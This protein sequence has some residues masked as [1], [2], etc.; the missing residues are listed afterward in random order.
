MP[1]WLIT[2]LTFICLIVISFFVYNSFVQASDIDKDISRYALFSLDKSKRVKA[3]EKRIAEHVATGDARVEGEHSK[4]WDALNKTEKTAFG[5]LNDT[6]GKRHLAYTSKLELAQNKLMQELDAYEKSKATLEQK[7]RGVDTAFAKTGTDVDKSGVS[8]TNKIGEFS[9]KV[10]KDF[11]RLDTAFKFITADFGKVI[12]QIKSDV[13]TLKASSSGTQN[14]IELSKK[15]LKSTLLG[16]IS[17]LTNQ[18]LNYEKTQNTLIA[19]LDDK[20][21]TVAEKARLIEHYMMMLSSMD[22]TIATLKTNI[23]KIESDM[24][25]LTRDTI[26]QLDISNNG[27]IAQ[28]N[29]V[30][31]ALNAQSSAISEYA[32]QLKAD[33]ATL[34][35]ALAT[36]QKQFT[37]SAPTAQLSTSL[38][39]QLTDVQ[40]QLSSYKTQMLAT[41]AGQKGTLIADQERV[42]KLLKDLAENMPADLPAELTKIQ[43][44][45]TTFVQKRDA[46]F[47]QLNATVNSQ[48]AQLNDMLPKAKALQD[49]ISSK[50]PSVTNIDPQI[51]DLKKRIVAMTVKLAEYVP[52]TRYSTELEGVRQTLGSLTTTLDGVKKSNTESWNKLGSLTYISP[53]AMKKEMA[54]I[55]GVSPTSSLVG[56]A[57]YTTDTTDLKN[58]LGSVIDLSKGGQV[59]G[60]LVVQG[61][62]KAQTGNVC[63]DDVCWTKA[64]LQKVKAAG[65]ILYTFTSHTFTTAGVS[66]RTGPTLAQ[67]K[68]AYSSASW[69][70]NTNFFN[71]TTQGIQLWTVPS[72]K[73]YTITVAG[74]SAANSGSFQGGKGS[75]V[76]STF[77]LTQGHKLLI[78]VGQQSSINKQNNASGGG[79]GT[80]VV[81]ETTN[82]LMLAAGGGGGANSGS[83]ASGLD[84]PNSQNGN[85]G[86]PG[87]NG[88]GGGFSGLPGST[89]VGGGG[90]GYVSRGNQGY[91]GGKGGFSLSSGGNGG[92]ATVYVTS[93]SEVESG[94][95]GFGGGGG[96]ANSGPGGGGGYSGGS[97]GNYYS[98]YGSLQ[99]GGGGLYGGTYKGTNTG[100]GY[101]TI[102]ML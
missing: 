64:Q 17:E 16:K 53:E 63:I 99:G 45:L 14:S 76:S 74:A 93:L 40:K 90:A 65:D 32:S 89:N 21:N 46:E 42:D 100:N 80:F 59:S 86:N 97:S 88:A 101:A 19:A 26:P 57:Q 91:W 68:S 51:D 36:A 87:L 24:T 44:E 85:G 12:N 41:L 49:I 82:T 18:L 72:T 10:E 20:S 83:G 50:L 3:F 38:Q 55:L 8:F 70:Q 96:S 47:T 22:E 9:Q 66:G 95:G 27:V 78:L 60:N 43:G 84:A 61:N 69:A 58:Q 29:G 4:D 34:E 11:S 52:M 39:A 28:F 77:S 71:M 6:L 13:Q 2:L 67:C 37:E 23:A 79:G 56:N 5:N 7:L 62:M 54:A 75:I 15:D 48:S 35:A 33:V 98:G 25:K 102:V 1:L 81:N 92:Y 30:D 31:E 94:S 73:S